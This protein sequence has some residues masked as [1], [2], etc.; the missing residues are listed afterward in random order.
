MLEQRNI[1]RALVLPL[2][3]VVLLLAA[4]GSSG[5]GGSTPATSATAATPPAA[6]A[7]T[8]STSTTTTTSTASTSTATSTTTATVAGTPPCRAALLSLSFLGQQGGMGHGEIGFQLRNTSTTSCRTYGW[9]GIQ[10]LDQNGGPLPTIPHHTTSD[11]FGNSTAI[12]LVLAPGESASF[13]LD[14]GHGVVTSNGCATAY[15]LQVIPP[16]DTA[17][18][19]TS[20]PNGAYE[21]RDA[22]VSPLRAGDSAYP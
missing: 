16:N 5:G 14:V 6:S 7:S 10:F 17:T 19:R 1:R 21:C 2:L 22:N 4:C 18:L 13:R 20:I 12:P 11:F 15:G 8:S 9:P 3:G